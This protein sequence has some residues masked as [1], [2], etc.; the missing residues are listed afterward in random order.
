MHSTVRK[1]RQAG[2]IIYQAYS[3]IIFVDI[4][5]ILFAIN[6]LREGQEIMNIH[7]LLSETPGFV[8]LTIGGR[9]GGG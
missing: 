7:N 5:R 1:R 9:G 4:L 3:S 6:Y 8:H 2:D